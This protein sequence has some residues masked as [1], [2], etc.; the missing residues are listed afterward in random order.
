MSEKK[1]DYLKT[2]DPI[3]DQVY[4]VLSMVNPKDRVILKNIHYINNFL[5]S[6]VNKMIIA[7]AMHMASELESLMDK[8]INSTLDKL[9]S[10]TNEEDK[11]LSSI[12]EKKYRGMK[13]DKDDFIYNCNRAYELDGE[14]LLDKF[15][16]YIAENRKKLDASFADAYGNE[17]STRGIKFTGAFRSHKEAE[18]AARKQRLFEPAV[19]TYTA[20]VGKWLP[21]DFEGDE[22][23]NSE[24]ME[25]ELNDLMRKYQEGVHARNKFFEE[26]KKDMAEHSKSSVKSR[27]KEKLR[28]K[29]REKLRKDLEE[30]K[31]N[32]TE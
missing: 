16:I 17:C 6:D 14:E 22:I 7:Q 10:S 23:Q 5:V 9:K 1:T 29:R 26:R 2:N 20:A 13:I 32:T 3:Y 12:L 4:C 8:R 25:P 15:K 11:L 24:Y 18:E 27:L 30:F 21:V 19:P 28:Q 31:K